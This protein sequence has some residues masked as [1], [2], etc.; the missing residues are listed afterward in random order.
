[1]TQNE[2]VY[3]ICYR[4]KVGDDVVS[5]RNVKTIL[6]HIV[7]TLK[8]ASST[9]F[10]DFPKRLFCDGE[11]GDGSGGMNAICSLP[12]VAGDVISGRM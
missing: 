5:G 7:V 10:R 8:V 12:E 3:A 2:H 9:S 6:S 4:P 1:M 11:V